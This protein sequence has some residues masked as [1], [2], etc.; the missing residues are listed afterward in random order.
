[1]PSIRRRLSQIV[2]ALSLLASA[3]LHAQARSYEARLRVDGR[4][5]TYLVDLPPQYDGRRALP[6]VL[7]LHGGGGN[8]AQVRRATGMTELARREGFI[9]VYPN[10]SGRGRMLTWNNG[11][12]C[13]WAMRERMDDTRFVRAL[14]DSLQATL[15]IDPA[16]VY[17]AGHSNGGMMAYQAACALGGRIAAIGVVAGELTT[18]ECRPPRPVSVVHVH[19]T[20][21]RNL[22]FGGGVGPD[23]RQAHP[24]RPVSYAIDTWRRIDGCPATPAVSREGTVTHT[25]YGPCA[26]GT[27][28]ELY[29]IEGGGHAWP[30]ARA[31]RPARRRGD[32]PSRAL[33]ATAVLWRFFA[34]HPAR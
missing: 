24:A 14:L 32:P 27:T 13:G 3:G 29:A 23:A 33:D 22:P 9:A 20:A 34:A 11:T 31:S 18:S 10:G 4:E 5:R 25:H 7:V 26:A 21:D 17:A 28:V 2:I 6:L 30:G 8:G 15:R 12:C 1:M 19:G 16:R